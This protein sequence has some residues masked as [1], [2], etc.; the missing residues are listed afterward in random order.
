[1]TENG[2]TPELVEHV[3]E[4]EGWRAKVYLCPAGYP[5]IGY[6]HRVDSLAHPPITKEEGEKLLRSDLWKAW[7]AA[8]LVS[9][10]LEQA[11]ARRQAAIIDFVFNVGSGKYARSTLRTMVDRG[12]WKE[13][14]VQ[15][16]KWVYAR[17]PKTDEM[18]RLP[19]LVKRREPPATWLE[20]G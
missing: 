16:R 4:F 2:I 19:G 14:A 18:V 11:S 15:I 3:K 6:G 17:D 5:T 1:V 9:P 20:Q 12:W 8:I 7:N 13:A 10:K